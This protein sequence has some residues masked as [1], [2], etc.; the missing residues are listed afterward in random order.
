MTAVFKKIG[1]FQ[2]APKA[3]ESKL[4][5]VVDWSSW[6]S[7]GETISNTE[8]TVESGLTMETLTESNGKV[9]IWL[10]GG[11]LGERYKVKCKI[12]TTENRVEIRT[13]IVEIVER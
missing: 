9:S 11:T 7:E 6:L 4:D 1:G 5:F 3:P 13:F 12:T 2:T 10:S 8:V